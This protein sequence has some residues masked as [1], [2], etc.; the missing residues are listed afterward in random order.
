[1]SLKGTGWI[2]PLFNRYMKWSEIIKLI[3][4]LDCVWDVLSLSL[5]HTKIVKLFTFINL[6]I[7]YIIKSITPVLFINPRM[8]I[9]A[10]MIV[11]QCFE[12]G[13]LHRLRLQQSKPCWISPLI[14]INK[15]ALTSLALSRHAVSKS[16][17]LYN[18]LN[19]TAQTLICKNCFI[20]GWVSLTHSFALKDTQ[21]MYILTHT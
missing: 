19:S 2:V 12:F 15:L 11:F 16:L 4:C 17:K 7:Y 3:V 21:S 10:I 14:A 13:W 9:W 18:L 20:Q 6:L 1:M 8:I 5:I